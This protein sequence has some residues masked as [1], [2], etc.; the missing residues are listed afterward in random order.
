MAAHEFEISIGPDGTVR[1]AVSGIKG[2]ACRKYAAQL[3]ELLGVE[4]S[5]EPSSE[6]FEPEVHENVDVELDQER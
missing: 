5:F 4:L 2:K 3:S 6:Y 1:G